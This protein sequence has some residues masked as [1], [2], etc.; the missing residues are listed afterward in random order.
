MAVVDLAPPPPAPLD[1]LECK[2]CGRC[3]AGILVDVPTGLCESCTRARRRNALMG[4][5]YWGGR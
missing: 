4:L 2:D 1:H 5:P 3:A